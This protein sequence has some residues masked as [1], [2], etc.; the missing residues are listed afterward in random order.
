MTEKFAYL[1]LAAL[2]LLA[3]TSQIVQGRSI[4]IKSLPGNEGVYDVIV[5]GGDAE[6]IAAAVA[7]ARC[8]AKTLL[9]DTRPVP[10]GL[11]TRGWL[12][13]IDLNLGHSG[14]PLNG[15]IFSEIYQQ[16]DDQ[17]FDVAHMAT[18]LARLIDSE[19]NLDYLSNA[20]TI[21]PIIGSDSRPL[22]MPGQTLCPD[23]RELP[24]KLLTNAQPAA[25]HATAPI[26]LAG[27]EIFAPT[28]QSARFNAK[29]LID[30]TQDADLAVAAGASW[31]LYGNDT[32]GEPRNMAITLVFRLSGISASDW[33]NMSSSLKGNRNNTDLLGGTRRSIWGFGEIMLEYK[34]TTGHLRMRGLNIGRQ[35]DGSVLINALL[36]FGFD[37]LNR[38]SRRE[39]RRLAEAELPHLLGFMQKRIPGMAAAEI[40]GTAPELYVRTSRQIATQHILSV[41]EVLENRDFADRIAFGSY[42]LDIQA[43][44]PGQPGDVTGKP[45]QYAVPLRSLIPVG[46]SN[47]LV[48][49]RSAGFASLAQSS[50]RTVPV[51][52]AAGQGAGVT[53]FIS[54]RDNIFFD[55]IATTVQSIVDIQAM[56]TAQGVR[57]GPNP[58]GPPAETAH[59]AYAGLRFMRRHGHVSGGY[60]N[61]YRLDDS[62]SARAFANRL[63]NL[64]R[65]LDKPAR[66]RLYQIAG[67]A[68]AITL[69]EACALLE[70][71]ESYQSR[72]FRSHTREMDSRFTPFADKRENDGQLYLSA[73]LSEFFLKGFSCPENI[74]NLFEVHSVPRSNSADAVSEARGTALPALLKADLSNLRSLSSFSSRGLFLPPWPA[75]LN[76]SQKTLSRGA[77]FMLLSRWLEANGQ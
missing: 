27:V 32:W 13:T 47:L 30:A 46:F 52:I 72:L 59:W 66:L 65:D 18:L 4:D 75:E 54:I 55:R 21:L 36:V 48:V 62:I 22:F 69:G 67:D 10:G 38:D 68:E 29:R 70:Q 51:G 44:G 1:V 24:E 42:P 16:L 17:S 50:A 58:A 41:D 2:L 33:A 40:A 71:A 64:R 63:V 61:D 8:G 12:N 28:G 76:D 23:D 45:E 15:G 26:T 34:A 37:G 11:L 57:I 3:A 25:A 5:T 19:P 7:A 73:F 20:L 60:A 49:G 14:L 31:A 35:N 53:A 9:V 56:L 39:A 74:K 6:G 77:A 43:Q